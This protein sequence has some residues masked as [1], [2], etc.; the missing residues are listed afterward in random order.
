V[1]VRHVVDERFL[2]EAQAARLRFTC[3]DCLLFLPESS[4]CA[5]EWPNQD[6]LRAPGVGEDVVFCKEFE[7][8]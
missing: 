4:M 6:H 8:V 5:H 1:Y 2:Q 3:R 7:L